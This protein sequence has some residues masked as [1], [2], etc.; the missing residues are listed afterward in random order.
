MTALPIALFCGA[1]L[2]VLASMVVTAK[3]YGAGVVALQRQCEGADGAAAHGHRKHL[4]YARRLKPQSSWR[5]KARVRR[6]GHAL[7]RDG[8]VLAKQGLPTRKPVHNQQYGF[9]LAQ[10]ADR[11]AME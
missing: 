8:G 5:A 7:R 3:Q 11:L 1:A 4:V 10:L 2:V 6:A 9:R